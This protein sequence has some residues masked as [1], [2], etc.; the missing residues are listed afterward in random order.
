MGE[1]APPLPSGVLGCTI[2][3]YPGHIAAPL[4][5]GL[6]SGDGAFWI[7]PTDTRR[8]GPC[9]SKGART[10]RNHRC[11]ISRGIW[12]AS[13]RFHGGDV[14]T[15]SNR[16]CFQIVPGSDTPHGVEQR[17]LQAPRAA[18]T[19]LRRRAR[20]RPL[21]CTCRRRR[22]PHM[23]CRKNGPPPSQTIVA[24][25]VPDGA[26]RVRDSRPRQP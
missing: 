7:Q 20:G 22:A 14:G 21:P 15:A 2:V 10:H 26:P 6:V 18:C 19:L 5:G 24:A 9:A 1:Y 23:T 17:G 4:V 25:A 8:R 13:S 11:R 12:A 3:A 16:R